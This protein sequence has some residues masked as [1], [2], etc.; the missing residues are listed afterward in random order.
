MD[1]GGL[2]MQ[3]VRQMSRR[4]AKTLMFGEVCFWKCV[5]GFERNV[6][7]GP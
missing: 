4:G 5:D 6:R 2:D 1:D 3:E 7:H